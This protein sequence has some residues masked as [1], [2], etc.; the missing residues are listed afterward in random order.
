GFMNASKLG[1]HL[2]Q[3]SCAPGVE[4][5]R[6]EVAGLIVEHGSFFAATLA[7]GSRIDARVFVLAAGPLLPEW[8][9][10]LALDVPIVN[11]LHGKIS[12]EDDDGVIPWEEQRMIW[13]Q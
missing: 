2:L 8:T 3:R 7:S 13:N 4:V 5:I 1:Q 11:E 10:R 12:F 9:D 6:D